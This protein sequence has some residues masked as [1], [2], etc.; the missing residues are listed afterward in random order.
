MQFSKDALQRRFH[1]VAPSAGTNGPR[2]GRTEVAPYN[3]NGA[4]PLFKPNPTASKSFKALHNRP[5]PK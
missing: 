2:G 3:K 1:K 4:G 5:S